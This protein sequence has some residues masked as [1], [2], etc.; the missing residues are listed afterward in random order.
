M[1]GKRDSYLLALSI[2]LRHVDTSG[3]LV[4]FSHVRTCE[5]A[6]AI[7]RVVVG[8]VFELQ[9]SVDRRGWGGQV[10]GCRA[11]DCMGSMP[12]ARCSS[13]PVRE[14]GR[15]SR[16]R[17]LIESETTTRYNVRSPIRVS[18]DSPARRSILERT[19]MSQVSNRLY[20]LCEL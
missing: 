3:G 8:D 5:Y 6:L 14:V 18:S 7:S 11:I 12:W 1:K 16:V 17:I 10:G 15:G 9:T 13:W 2:R 20:F 19:P 4:D